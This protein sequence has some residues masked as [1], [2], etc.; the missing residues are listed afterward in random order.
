[1]METN[2]RLKQARPEATL[3]RGAAGGTIR[4]R[5]E[6]IRRAD[7]KNRPPR[8]TRLGKRDMGMAFRQRKRA[9]V[10]NVRCSIKSWSLKICGEPGNG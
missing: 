6:P 3:R 7:L 2:R 8:R 10:E 5:I 9:R 1:M 4:R